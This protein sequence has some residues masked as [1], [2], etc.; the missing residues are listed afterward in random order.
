MISTLKAVVVSAVVGAYNYV[1]VPPPSVPFQPTPGRHY[2]HG[3]S[4][5]DLEAVAIRSDGKLSPGVSYFARAHHQSEPYARSRARKRDSKSIVLEFE[6]DALEPL[7]SFSGR[8][9]GQYPA[10][11]ADAPVPLSGLT[12]LSK[13]AIREELDRQGA[14]DE[15][16]A[17][18]ERAF[19]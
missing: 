17:A 9:A 19:E 16:R 10:Y 12:P 13:Q 6:D 15:V 2:Y 7:T 1:F 18:F 5:K 8:P 11:R 4:W 14:S 3:T